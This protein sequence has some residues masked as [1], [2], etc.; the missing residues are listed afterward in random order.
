M[1]EGGVLLLSHAASATLTFIV[2]PVS[3]SSRTNF[4]TPPVR[5]AE[6]SSPPPCRNGRNGWQKRQKRQKRLAETS[7]VQLLLCMSRASLGKYS[8]FSRK[9]AKE[10]TFPHRAQLVEAHVFPITRDG[11]ED[12][13]NLGRW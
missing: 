5:L 10:K 13:E 6:T 3:E 8:G 4:V 11:R 12:R 2:P 9:M 7:S 1:A